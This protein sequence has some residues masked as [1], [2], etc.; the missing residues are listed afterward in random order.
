MKTQEEL[1]PLRIS[2]KSLFKVL[3]EFRERYAEKSITFFTKS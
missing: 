2:D 1:V 3:A